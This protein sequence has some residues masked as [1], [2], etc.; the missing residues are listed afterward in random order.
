MKTQVV[1]AVSFCFL[2]HAVQP[3]QAKTLNSLMDE[4]TPKVLSGIHYPVLRTAYSL[5]AI[6]MMLQKTEPHLPQAAI[7][8]VLSILKCGQYTALG[9]K[10]LL[11]LIDYSLP[12]SEKR[13]WIF[14]LNQKKLLFHTYVSHGIRSGV[15]ASNY[16]SNQYNSK[17]SSIGVY[18]TDKPYYGRHGLSLKLAG[19]DASFN[20]NADGRAVVMHGGWYVDEAFIKKYGRAGRS[21]GCPAVPETLHQSIIHTIK[22][23]SILIAYYPNDRWFK[24]SKFLKCDRQPDNSLATGA[25]QS[26]SEIEQREPIYFAEAYGKHLA[27]ETLPVVVMS[28]DHYA[29]CFQTTPPLT[30]MLRRQIQN[31]EYIALT[32]TEIQQLVGHPETKPD[33]YFVIPRIKMVRGYYATEMQV[34][35]LGKIKAIEANTPS[36]FTVQFETRS[37]VQIH[38]SSQFVRWIG[39]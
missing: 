2:F 22:E 13:L 35:D 8:K 11:T 3:I 21:W 33:I 24:Q 10:S 19:L 37:P 30:R 20:D 9:R 38:A 6:Q 17:A 32:G 36:S 14:D 23:D 25:S 5:S 1:S 34:V 16:F 31:Q 4:L 26:V 39:L 18:A 27:S 12:S 15:F 29:Q 28:A 7:N